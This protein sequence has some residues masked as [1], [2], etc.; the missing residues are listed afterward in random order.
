MKKVK[1]SVNYLYGEMCTIAYLNVYYENNLSTCAFT[2]IVIFC[3]LG[4][5]VDIAVHIK[6]DENGTLKET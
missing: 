6:P 1:H 4:D 2:F 3:P 5:S